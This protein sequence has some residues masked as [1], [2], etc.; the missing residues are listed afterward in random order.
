M[1]NLLTR[2]IDYLKDRIL[3]ILIVLS[4]PLLIAAAV[5]FF[6]Q[7]LTNGILRTYA[8]EEI[9]TVL[10]TISVFTTCLSSFC[11]AI[12]CS[13]WVKTA[14]LYRSPEMANRAA[15]QSSYAIIL[16]DLFCGLLLMFFCKPILTAFNVPPAVFPAVRRYYL[17]YV[18]TLFLSEVCQYFATAV[19]GQVSSVGILLMSI[20]N[21]VV[22]TIV[23]FLLV[24]VL[25][26]N[27]IGVGLTSAAAGV[28]LT[29]CF[30]FYMRHK[31]VFSR[32]KRRDYLPDFRFIFEIIGYGLLRSM[33]S[34]FVTAGEIFVL[35]NTNLLDADFI[36]CLSVS[37]PVG[38]LL[39]PMGTA[40]T[41]FVPV[42]FQTGNEAR[43]K[44]FLRTD[45]AISAAAG[46]VCAAIYLLLA[47]PYFTS[48][49]PDNPRVVEYGV[50]YW[51]YY[52]AAMFFAALLTPMLNF[53]EAIGY[54]WFY[55]L[56][57]V[58]EGAS[59]LVCAFVLIP[60][61]GVFGR[62]MSY[63]LGWIVGDI[64][65]FGGYLLLRKKIYAKCRLYRHTQ[66]GLP[67]KNEP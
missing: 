3:I 22:P 61:F 54:N 12:R 55:M 51:R 38:A 47:R 32:P 5:G 39:G 18:L 24:G 36:T 10:G 25:K 45:L 30:V 64:A 11:S 63:L 28:V 20:L 31:R 59:K 1:K 17:A 15:V 46:L 50:V 9:F 19:C 21:T 66:E 60:A 33:Q 65:L 67:C 40:I 23:S 52:A 58:F 2:K 41:L 56:E 53:Y 13:A 27:E 6:T 16:F 49:F 29:V 44:R 8:G 26:L 37:L 14:K 57:G 7:Y 35:R 62:N 4:V 48:L 34:V 43:L 42:N